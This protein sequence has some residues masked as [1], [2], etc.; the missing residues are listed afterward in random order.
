MKYRL[1]G[2]DGISK[3]PRAP[4]DVE[5]DTEASARE[6]GTQAGMEV[7]RVE[8]L[9]LFTSAEPTP[10]P[11]GAVRTAPVFPGTVKAAGIIS[12]LYGALGLASLPLVVLLVAVG[13]TFA[14]GFLLPDPDAAEKKARVLV[15]GSV[16]LLGVG[17]IGALFLYLG[18]RVLRGA[19]R[20]TL[21]LA[22]LCLASGVLALVLAIA[23][24]CC[25][26]EP[27]RPM[28]SADGQ[29]VESEGPLVHVRDLVYVGGLVLAGYLALKGRPAYLAWRRT[30]DGPLAAATQDPRA[31]AFD[32][33]P[34]DGFQ[35]S[36]IGI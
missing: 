32:R 20:D 5:T 24:M 14:G 35:K 36:D 17:L 3:E 21:A 12:I 1:Y 29:P 4:L 6:Q 18:A 11:S 23:D 30:Q 26:E 27:A 33:H 25:V 8:P 28:F 31:A 22:W 10:G 16:I 9:P 13:W 7:L 34:N 2:Q 15:L 19:A